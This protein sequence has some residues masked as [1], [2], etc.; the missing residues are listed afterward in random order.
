M[1]GDFAFYNGG[2]KISQS[3]KFTISDSSAG[4]NAGIVGSE[5]Q[6]STGFWHMIAPKEGWF[7]VPN[8]MPSGQEIVR[9]NFKRDI[10]ANFGR[11]GVVMLDPD[12]KPENE[13]P[14]KP[15]ELYPQAPT[16]EL[17]VERAAKLW[18]AYTKG[19]V[20]QHLADAEA[21]RAAGGSPIGARGFTKACLKLWNITDP[22]EQ[23]FKTLQGGNGPT[24]DTKTLLAHMQQ[25]N[26][27]MMAIVLAVATGQKI[28]PEILKA[29]APLASPLGTAPAAP[30]TSGIATGEIKKPIGD[31]PD[32]WE[33]TEPVAKG[34]SKRAELAA[35]QL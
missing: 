14:D 15:L 23:Y 26:Q 20:A 22:A 27:T 16:K 9:V 31:R 32:G 35:Q 2:F 7:S 10:L 24:D 12:W 30:V 34:K 18:E 6:A 5:H 4:F 25:Q 21:S 17:V 13:D 3:F 19:I 11:Q 1:H 33:K 29:M 8:E 28:D